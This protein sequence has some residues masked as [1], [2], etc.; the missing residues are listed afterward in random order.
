MAGR[1]VDLDRCD[2]SAGRED[3]ARL[4]QRRDRVREVL[5]EPHHPDVVERLVVE[6]QRQRVGLHQRRVDPGRCQVRSRECELPCLDIDAREMDAGEF[7]AEHR[8]HGTHAAADLQQPGPGLERRSVPDQVVPPVFR[9][10]NQ[11]LLLRRCVSVHVLGHETEAI[12][13]R[14]ERARAAHRDLILRGYVLI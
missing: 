7:L 8:H 5:Q 6:G 14:G 9:L 12:A 3:A 1:V 2:R 13:A 11:A 10:R 4:A